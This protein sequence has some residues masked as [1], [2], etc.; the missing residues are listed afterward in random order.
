[1]KTS[2]A[3]K[4]LHI[5]DVQLQTTETS[6]KPALRSTSTLCPLHLKELFKVVLNLQQLQAAVQARHQLFTPDLAGIP[7]K[8]GPH[9]SG[10]VWIYQEQCELLSKVWL[11]IN[12]ELSCTFS[13]H[14]QQSYFTLNY[15]S[16]LY[17]YAEGRRQLLSL[18][19]LD[20]L[21]V[22]VATERQTN[23]VS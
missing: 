13:S 19:W 11:D 16:V 20:S 23:T 10:L 12:R 5:Q 7:Q 15:I 14:N 1:M 3:P 22:C 21:C 6:V 9:H 17:K 2:A 4:A 18:H 8:W